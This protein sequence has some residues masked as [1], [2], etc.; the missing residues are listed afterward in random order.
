MDNLLSQQLN[1]P[2]WTLAIEFQFYLLLPIIAWLLKAMVRR[3]TVHWRMLKL[4][5]WLLIMI[6]WG[7]LTRYWGLFIA[8]TP[9]LDFLIPHSISTTLIPF[10]YG[11]S[12]GYVG[13]AVRN[14]SAAKTLEV[15]FGTSLVLDVFR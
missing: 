3:G 8:D 11:D 2:F 1:G 15:K 5:F 14:G 12:S 13:I 7:L 10:I 6:A 4:S 9:K